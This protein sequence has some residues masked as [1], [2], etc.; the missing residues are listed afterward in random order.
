MGRRYNPDNFIDRGY[1]DFKFAELKAELI[2]YFDSRIRALQ[3]GGMEKQPE[4]PTERK[5][6]PV[7][8]KEQEA[9]PCM[10]WKMEM[11]RRCKE[12]C[13]NYPRQHTSLNSVLG[14]IYQ[15][16][17]GQYGV[18]LDQYEKEYKN[19]S[20]GR[21]SKLEVISV[22]DNLRSLFEPILEDMEEAC[23]LR[24]EKEKAVEAAMLNRTRQEIIQPLIDARNDHSIYGSATY[25]AVSARMR[26]KGIDIEAEKEAYRKKKGIKRQINRN[27]LFDNDAD[28][29]KIFAETVAELLH[30]AGKAAGHERAS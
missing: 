24:E 5:T 1:M 20:E 17:D 29:K 6:A 13:K 9:D 23:R 30:E 3:E 14:K 11:R 18:C 25:S 27:E 2:T 12:M 8:P 26:K 10:E 7:K 16:M 4:P 15:K 19:G 28:M 21:V 22:H